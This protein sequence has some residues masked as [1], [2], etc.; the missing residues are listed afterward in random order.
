MRRGRFPAAVA[1]VFAF[2]FVTASIASG[3]IAVPIGL[4]SVRETTDATTTGLA[5]TVDKAA[6]G[7]TVITVSKTVGSAVSTTTTTFSWSAS[8]TASPSSLSLNPGESQSVQY[9]IRATRS[10][11]GQSTRNVVTGTI[12]VGNAGSTDAVS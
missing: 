3:A 8:K 12:H 9:T 10:N 7:S 4:R 2:V 1:A 5:F 11:A 6:T